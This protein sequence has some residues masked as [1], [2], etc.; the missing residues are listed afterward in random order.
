ME[1]NVAK[2]LIISFRTTFAFW[3]VPISVL[4][5]TAATNFVLANSN[6]TEINLNEKN[7]YMTISERTVLMEEK[8]REYAKL[9]IELGVNVQPGQTLVIACPVDC[10]QFA[11]LCGAEA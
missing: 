4:V 5:A 6:A 10:A 11:L 1:T 7:M 3:P 2:P 8:L 9:L